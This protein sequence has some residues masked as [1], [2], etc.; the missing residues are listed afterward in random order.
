MK[1]FRIAFALLSIFC[2]VNSIFPLQTK[3][4]PP[5]KRRPGAGQNR[6]MPTTISSDNYVADME[7]A[8][9]WH[10]KRMPLKVY[11]HDCSSVERFDPRFTDEFKS[12][13]NE[14][15]NASQGKIRFEYTDNLEKSDV[16]VRWTSDRSDWG[17]LP[18][19][20]ELGVTAVSVGGQEGINH[21]EIKIL[22]TDLVLNKQL[23]LKAIR[24]IA[25]HEL[26][27]AF[28]LWH[29]SIESDIMYSSVS[30]VPVQIEGK[31]KME[32]SPASPVNLSKRDIT[33]M[34]V[35][36]QAKIT[37]DSIREKQLETGEACAELINES[38]RQ[39]NRGDYAQGI[40]YLNEVLRL[41]SNNQIAM[42]NLI[43]TYYNCGVAKYNRQ[44]FKQAI[45]PIDRAMMLSRRLGNES[46]AQQ[47][48]S[49]KASCERAVSH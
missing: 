23:G 4:A 33:T 35:I 34:N 46:Q 11:I 28:G 45:I 29:S 17:A 1:N 47:M 30:L 14:W 20:K 3:A 49:L 31:E 2:A 22:T 27:H 26:G 12:A 6:Y 5:L 13:C 10:R 40:I 37:L 16:D 36:Y 39:N 48:S 38:V 42:R 9:Y 8:E 25:L 18:H 21:A 24:S 15:T 32:L 41:D 44:Q 7:Y 19:G 43:A